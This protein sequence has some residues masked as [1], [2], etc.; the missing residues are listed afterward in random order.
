MHQVLLNIVDFFRDVFQHPEEILN[1]EALITYGGMALLFFAV[2]A[3]TG[4]FFCF[5]FPGDALLFTA[6]VFTATGVFHHHIEVVSISIVIAAFLGNLCGYWFGRSTG[7]LLFKRKDSLFFHH[8]HLTIANKFFDSYGGLALTAGFF[9]PIIRT[10][11]PII[12]GVIKYQFVRFAMFSLLGAVLWANTL[13]LSGYLLGN[14]PF[15]KRNLEFIVVGM[16]LIITLPVVFKLLRE[17]GKLK[18]K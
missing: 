12:S 9:L 16:I 15:V 14:I 13:V 11:T 10:F 2:F 6:G 18:T 7:P 4:L 1:P 17:I 3:Q 8:N 5:F